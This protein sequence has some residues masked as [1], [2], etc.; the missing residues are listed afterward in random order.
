MGTKISPNKLFYGILILSFGV[1]GMVFIQIEGLYRSRALDV[2]ELTLESVWN[3]GQRNIPRPRA[4]PKHLPEPLD[5]SMKVL[6]TPP[7]PS[8]KPMRMKPAESVLP[9]PLM[10]RIDVASVPHV[11]A[12]GVSHVDFGS[13]VASSSERDKAAESYLDMV[14]SRIERR[15]RYPSRARAGLKEGRTLVYFTIT[16]KGEVRSLRVLES[17]ATRILDDAALRAVRSAA[18]FPAPP[19]HLFD[20]D[21]HLELTIVFKLT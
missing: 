13:V 11:P 14:R 10:E 3:R 15:K 17:S 4:R 20:E 21:I 18:P 8:L 9:E 1:H 2:I 7:M 5:P 19:S 12:A 16:T 6:E